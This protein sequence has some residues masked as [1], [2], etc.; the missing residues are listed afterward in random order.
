MKR[1]TTLLIVCCLGLLFAASTCFGQQYT[2][3]DLGTLSGGTSSVAFGINAS[4]QVVGYSSPTSGNVPAHAFRTGPSSPI[5]PAT[6]DL[7]TLGGTSS[8]AYG[9]NDSG[10]VVGESNTI[11]DAA[12]HA[13]RTA[14]NSPIDPATDDLGTL[15]ITS[16][17]PQGASS[18]SAYAINSSGQ[19]VG[20]SY[21]GSNV[22]AH[23]FRTAANSPINP[24]T[25]DL[26]TLGGAGSYSQ[27]FGINA[28]GQVVGTSLTFTG[29]LGQHAFRTAANS[30]INPATDDLGTFGGTSTVFGFPNS[31]AR[32]I[33]A[34][35]QVVGEASIGD[36][37]DF[38]AFRTAANT[39]INLAT[40]DLGTLG[41]P[42]SQ[43]LGINASGD[44]V[45]Y[46]YTSSVVSGA[47]LQS[48]E[49]A[50]LYRAGV[51]Y[52]LNNLI[53]AG[54][55]WVLRVAYGINDAGQI[56]GFGFNPS[57]VDRA[58]LLNPALSVSPRIVD[59][60]TVYL[61][62]L[63]LRMVTLKNTG[64]VAAQI[65]RVSVTTPS[66]DLDEFISLSF[67]GKSLIPGKSCT[68][69]VV[70]YA[71]DVATDM[72]TLNIGTPYGTLQV[73]II[74]TVVKRH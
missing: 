30:P 55:G 1:I 57:G 14:A 25:D 7:G 49:H 39:P 61:G 69:A 58:F 5:N 47:V 15:G 35:G 38:N 45:G 67:C 34:S 28:S 54:S 72:A 29:I 41:G 22:P 32:G 60:G 36:Y 12:S 9:I 4:G 31:A 71:D 13:F 64:T 20:Y 53:P 65:G 11:G 3:T 26:G 27:A 52:D 6:D 70:F 66:G 43:A 23:A 63:V 68:I 24:A 51:I 44:V 46:S 18:S 50:F 37:P 21:T 59:F 40:D 17:P 10:Q 33:N 48:S 19:V 73:P 74:A 16:N 62:R 56:V 42:Q 2:V 8:V